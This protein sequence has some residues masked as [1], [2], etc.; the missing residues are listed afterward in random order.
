MIARQLS[1]PRCKCVYNRPVHILDVN[2]MHGDTH[3]K[4]KF[5]ILPRSPPFL[6]S[7]F[8]TRGIMKQM[9]C[10]VS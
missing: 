6:K 10:F 1:L 5:W 4:S 3:S 8:P 2:L 7:G 9:A